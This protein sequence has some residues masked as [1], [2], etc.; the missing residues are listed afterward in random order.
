MLSRNTTARLIWAI[1]GSLAAHAVVMSGMPLNLAAPPQLPP[2]LEARLEPAPPPV[3]AQ[4]PAPAPAPKRKPAATR[5]AAV[6]APVIPVRRSVASTPLYVPPEWDLDPGPD[7]PA[8][9]EVSIA[10]AET[11]PPEAPPVAQQATPALPVNPLPRKGQIEYSVRYGSDDGLP[12]GKIVQSWEMKNGKYLLASDGETIGLLDFFRPQQLR[13]ISQGKITSSGLRPDAFFITRTRKG[14]TETARA[15]FDW[16]NRKILYG[17]ARDKKIATLEDGAQDL[18]SLA[19]HFSLSPPAPGRLRIPVT[20][21]RDLDLREIEVLPEEVI[22]TP[23]G[24]MRAL[25]LRQIARPG[26]EHFE[27]WLA[28]QYHYLPVRLR[29][30]DRNG[31]YTGEQVALEIRV[32]D[33]REL[34]QR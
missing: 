22:E 13:Y 34:A 10:E 30:F 17:Y 21:G 6:K 31:N 29:Y 20:S 24:Q 14:K 26:K 16:E 4:A 33:E 19:Y 7:V 28:I 32:S 8:V 11:T 1:T 23:M 3:V 27:L 25:R 12:V 18:I 5:Q 2:P 9:D 15:E